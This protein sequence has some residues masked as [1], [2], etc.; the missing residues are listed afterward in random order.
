MFSG[1]TQRAFGAVIRR[2][3]IKVARLSRTAHGIS[4]ATNRRTVL[5]SLR[6]LR[7]V[8]EKM[9]AHHVQRHLRGLPANRFTVA[10]EAHAA[11]LDAAVMRQPHVHC[12]ARLFF[13]TPAGAGDSRDAHPKR[14]AH[15]AANAL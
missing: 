2:S 7:A 8:V 12:A 14:A 4:S 5:S 15:A 11:L 13:A 1:R 6:G 10:G 3:L 9:D